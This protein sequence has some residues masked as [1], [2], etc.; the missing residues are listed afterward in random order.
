MLLQCCTYW[1]LK[2][3]GENNIR[4]LFL[5]RP[6][7]EE[8]RQAPGYGQ[9]SAAGMALPDVPSWSN[10]S[11]KP[12]PAAPAKGPL[13]LPKDMSSM[14]AAFTMQ[15]HART[16]SATPSLSSCSTVRTESQSSQ[17]ERCLE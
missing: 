12:A 5:A 14:A 2:E 1:L 8:T 9:V 13:P 3:L 4:Y 7:F 16:G 6:Q 10:E 11:L 15:Q 17:T